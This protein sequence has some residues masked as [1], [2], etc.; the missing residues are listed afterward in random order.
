[1]PIAEFSGAD[2]F[3]L[4]QFEQNAYAGDEDTMFVNNH[5]LYKEY[6][7]YDFHLDS[8]SPAIGIADADVAAVYPYDRDSISRTSSPDAGC[9]QHQ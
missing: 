2:T 4:P 6:R 9:Y 1:M 8:L 7:Y 5:Y 3:R